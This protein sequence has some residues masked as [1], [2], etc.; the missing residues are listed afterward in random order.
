M[1]KLARG[2]FLPKRYGPAVCKLSCHLSVVIFNYTRV[3]F[4]SS[5][6]CADFWSDTSKL[7]SGEASNR[8]Q[9][10]TLSLHFLLVSSSSLSSLASSNL[11][12]SHGCLVTSFS[13]KSHNTR[14]LFLLLHLD[15]ATYKLNELI[16]PVGGVE[17]STIAASIV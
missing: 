16:L 2:K 5:Y 3:V 9:Q 6:T 10:D 15:N 17:M 12:N 11:R 4:V 8:C 13:S 14:M 7:S 1:R